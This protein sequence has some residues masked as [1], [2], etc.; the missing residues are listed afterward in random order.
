M[1]GIEGAA[2]GFGLLLLLLF[3]GMHVATAVFMVAA[4]GAWWFFGDTMF[5]PFGTMMWSTLNN[6]LLVAI[7]LFIFMGEVLVRGGVTGR[8]YAALSD[9][10]RGIPGGL[11]HT[12]IA[13]SALFA[14]ISGSSVATAATIGT[15][16]FPEFRQRGYKESWVAGSI[17]AGATLGI[18][19][20][21]SINLIIYGALTNTSIG[22]LF[23]AGI[24]PGIL[25]ASLFSVFIVVASVLDHGIAGKRESLPPWSERRKRLIDLLPPLFIVIVV[26]G[27]IYAGFATPTEA[28]G[29]GA[30]ASMVL[31]GARGDLTLKLLK[32][33][34]LATASITAMTLLVLV[35]AFYLNFIL[36]VLG[37]PGQISGFVAGLDMPPWALMIALVVLYL[38]L[39]CFLDALAM[40]IST[41]PIVWP[42][43]QF[44]GYDSVWFGIFL[45]IMCELAL[46]TPP[47]G[48]NL[49][50]VQSVRRRGSITTVIAGVLPFLICFMVLVALIVAFP[51]L[52]GWLPSLAGYH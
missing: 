30:I 37:V 12:N 50:I 34:A 41:I 10:T 47:V 20:P 33:A 14:S 29:V 18:L 49:Y 42:L 28:A 25:L 36:G 35:A 48:M 27:S 16:A 7:P 44:L 46:I 32:E 9:W 52:V 3:L 31:V 39:G 4:T 38:I 43:I 21:P 8:M 17:A 24:V 5:R 13:S 1:L 45:V 15:V 22:Q 40:M 23:I 2:L 51:G 11:L 6:F 19:I 26:M